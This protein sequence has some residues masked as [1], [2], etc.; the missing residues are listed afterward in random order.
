MGCGCKKKS[1]QPVQET[2]QSVTIQITEGNSGTATTIT[3]T[4]QELVEKIVAKLNDLDQE[5]N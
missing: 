2:P 4:Q 1:N 5:S 3:E